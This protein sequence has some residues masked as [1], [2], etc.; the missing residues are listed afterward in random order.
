MTTYLS[1]VRWTEQS[2]N[3]TRVVRWKVEGRRK[4]Y[5][6]VSEH[7]NIPRHSGSVPI[8][9]RASDV[10]V[11][12]GPGLSWDGPEVAGYITVFGHS[13]TLFLP[14]LYLPPHHA[15]RIMTLLVYSVL[16]SSSYSTVTIN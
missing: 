12:R 15:R 3:P 5:S 4:E 6:G 7:G 8:Y 16:C 9:T 2:R 10:T 13:R 1:A 14:S 11:N